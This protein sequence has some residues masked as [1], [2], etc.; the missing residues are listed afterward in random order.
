MPYGSGQKRGM[1]PHDL[2][3]HASIL[4]QMRSIIHTRTAH[5]HQASPSKRIRIFQVVN[6][7]KS[8][9]TVDIWDLQFEQNIVSFRTTCRSV[10]HLQTHPHISLQHITVSHSQ[11]NVNF[12]GYTC[13]YTLLRVGSNSHL[14]LFH[15]LTHNGGL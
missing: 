14:L 9:N 13:N 11:H 6:L 10:G 1:R 12:I 15:Y 3:L 2:S 8:F 4:L 7:E 5:L